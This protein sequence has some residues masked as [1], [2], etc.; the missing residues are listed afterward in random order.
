MFGL[1][2]YEPLIEYDWV[3]SYPSYRMIE[4]NGYKS[5]KHSKLVE[6]SN[7]KRYTPRLRFFR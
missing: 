6:R 4:K 5:H 1:R 7:R 3:S 2:A